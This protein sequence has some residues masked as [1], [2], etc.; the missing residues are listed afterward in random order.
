[1]NPAQPSPLWFCTTS[2]LF[3]QLICSISRQS[4]RWKFV[5]PPRVVKLCGSS[6]TLNMQLSIFITPQIVEKSLINKICRRK[7]LC[8]CLFISATFTFLLSQTHS[9]HLQ[10]FVAIKVKLQEWSFC[11][12]VVV[13][14]R[15]AAL[16]GAFGF[17]KETLNQCT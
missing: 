9:Q 15:L 14:I 7:Q 17:L 4:F 2:F 8:S 11:T 3:L 13:P 5:L 16:H 12:Y 10:L 6:L 1:M